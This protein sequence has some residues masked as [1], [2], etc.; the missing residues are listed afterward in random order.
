MAQNTGAFVVSSHGHQTYNPRATVPPPQ[1][2]PTGPSKRMSNG[3]MPG[4][5]NP[6]MP[7]NMVHMSPSQMRPMGSMGPMKP[8]TAGIGPMDK[9]NSMSYSSRYGRKAW[10]MSRSMNGT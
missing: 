5:P 2:I 3:M 8:G 7:P 9:S 6:S 4:P 1:A 10:P